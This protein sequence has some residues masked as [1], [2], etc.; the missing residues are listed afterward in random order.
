MTEIT[1]MVAPETAE[2]LATRLYSGRVQATDI[3]G[4]SRD[5]AAKD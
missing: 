2:I 3:G 1:L 4:Y 5:E